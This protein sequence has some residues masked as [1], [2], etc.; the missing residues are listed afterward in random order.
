[1]NVLKPHLRNTVFTLIRKGIGQ[2]EIHRTTGI[3]RKTIRHYVRAMLAPTV[4][5]DPNSSTL[6]TGYFCRNITPCDAEARALGV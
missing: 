5:S 3:D 2:R 6:A 4:D 1:V